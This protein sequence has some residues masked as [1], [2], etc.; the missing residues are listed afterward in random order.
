M[1]LR[2]Q[3]K[4]DTSLRVHGEAALFRLAQ[5]GDHALIA[6]DGREIPLIARADAPAADIAHAVARVPGPLRPVLRRLAV[7]AEPNPTDA[8]WAR[9]YGMP[10]RAGMGALADGSGTVMIYPHGL[11]QL[12]AADRDAFVRGL[13]HELGHCWSLRAWI[14]NPAARD[15]WLAAIASDAEAPSQYALGA[16]RNSGRPDEDVAEATALRFL[17]LGTADFER[18][19]TAMPARFA[20]LAERFGDAR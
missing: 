9:L 7:S 16:F 2:L 8:E 14:E 20:L 10:V 1:E 13:M 18:A 6:I 19:R 11:E 15:A 17:L 3:V 12:H 4:S 5:R